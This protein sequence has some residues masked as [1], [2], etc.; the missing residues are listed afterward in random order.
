MDKDSISTK[1]RA[2]LILKE[3]F[4]HK[5]DG[6]YLAYEYAGFYPD[7]KLDNNQDILDILNIDSSDKYDIYFR[8]DDINIW[9]K[10]REYKTN[11]IM[12]NIK[13][14]HEH[15]VSPIRQRINDMFNNE[16]RIRLETC[17]LSPSGLRA[18][19][20]DGNHIFGEARAFMIN[21][22]NGRSSAIYTDLCHWASDKRDDDRDLWE[23]EIPPMNYG[24]MKLC[25]IDDPRQRIYI[26]M[27][28]SE[29]ELKNDKLLSKNKSNF[30][31]TACND[32]RT[33]QDANT[34]T[35][36]IPAYQNDNDVEKDLSNQIDD[37]EEQ[38]SKLE[39]QKILAQREKDF[40]RAEQLEQQIEAVNIDKDFIQDPPYDLS[41]QELKIKK[42]EK[43]Y[44]AFP[45]EENKKKVE[46]QKKELEKYPSINDSGDK[47]FEK[48]KTYQTDILLKIVPEEERMK[49]FFEASTLDDP[50]AVKPTQV[51]DKLG[52]VKKPGYADKEKKVN[53]RK[54]QLTEIGQS[55]AFYDYFQARRMV[56]LKQIIDVNATKEY[57]LDE[58]KM[59]KFVAER[60]SIYDL[61]YNEEF[62]KAYNEEYKKRFPNGNEEGISNTPILV[63]KKFINMSKYG[64]ST[65]TYESKDL[66]VYNLF[67]NNIKNSILKND[68]YKIYLNNNEWNYQENTNNPTGS[69]D[70]YVNKTDGFI[71]VGK[72]QNELKMRSFNNK[73]FDDNGTFCIFIEVNPTNVSNWTDIFLTPT[74]IGDLRIEASSKVNG[75]TREFVM[76]C[77]RGGEQISSTGGVPVQLNQWNRFIFYKSGDEIIL[78]GKNSDGTISIC[79]LKNSRL[80]NVR[81]LNVIKFVKRMSAKFRLTICNTIIPNMDEFFDLEDEKFFP[82]KTI[83]EWNPP[84]KEAYEEL[85]KAE[86]EA[87]FY[88]NRQDLN[89]LYESKNVNDMNKCDLTADIKSLNISEL[90]YLDRENVEYAKYPLLKAL[91]DEN[92]IRKSLKT[93]SESIKTTETISQYINKTFVD[94]TFY[95]WLLLDKSDY[96]D[97]QQVYFD[98]QYEANKSIPDIDKKMSLSRSIANYFNEHKFRIDVIPSKDTLE[99]ANYC[100]TFLLAEIS[101]YTSLDDT[102]QLTK[103]NEIKAKYEAALEK[104]DYTIFDLKEF[105]SD[106]YQFSSTEYDTAKSK[107]LRNIF[108]NLTED[109]NK[110]LL[111][112]VAFRIHQESISLPGKRY[113][114]I[115][116]K[117]VGQYSLLTQLI[118]VHIDE[119]MSNKDYFRQDVTEEDVEFTD[120]MKTNLASISTKIEE[121]ITKFND[122]LDKY[123]DFIYKIIFSY[124]DAVITNKFYKDTVENYNFKDYGLD[125]TN[126]YSQINKI[127]D[128]DENDD[129]DYE[130]RL[131]RDRIIRKRSLKYL[132]QPDIDI[133]LDNAYDEL[134]AAYDFNKI[135]RINELE[136]E[137]IP[138]LLR[139]K[140]LKESLNLT[141]DR[142]ESL[143]RRRDL[144]YERLEYLASIR[145]EDISLLYRKVTFKNTF[146]FENDIM[147]YDKLS[148]NKTQ[149]YVKY[150]RKNIELI[151][152]SNYP[153]LAKEVPVI[154]AEIAYC[155]NKNNEKS[156]KRTEMMEKL[157]EKQKEIKI[158]LQ[159]RN[160]DKEY[161]H[162]ITMVNMYHHYLKSLYKDYGKVETLPSTG[163]VIK[164]PFYMYE[165]FEAEYKRFFS[166]RPDI[167]I[168][169][170]EILDAYR[171]YTN[172]SF[173]LYHKEKA[174]YFIENRK[175]WRNMDYR[176]HNDTM[177]SKVHTYILKVPEYKDISLYKNIF[178]ILNNIAGYIFIETSVS[179]DRH[180][181][182]LLQFRR[183]SSGLIYDIKYFLKYMFGF[184]DQ[185]VNDN[186]VITEITD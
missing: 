64:P 100:M 170:Y 102:T 166:D 35:K 172:I 82:Y 146:D 184:S 46:T 178:Y 167:I 99:Y 139:L 171:K 36:V 41:E 83:P 11:K 74:S 175:L 63:N 179:N 109:M 85:F 98:T 149:K 62:K 52:P 134:K 37:L 13:Y 30:Y 169:N 4:D 10:N 69:G 40:K 138:E 95:T 143:L 145:R 159:K 77:G 51:N 27:P 111:A 115:C 56:L 110:R 50:S 128:D 84:L 42:A 78:K 154:E 15:M 26:T 17:Y 112:Y 108:T 135:P 153:E 71:Y 43:I 20:L 118:K 164:Y 94:E 176:P 80:S 70:I 114:N 28:F 32:L 155:E 158:E 180:K 23:E 142:L 136:Q 21:V 174:R 181:R 173:N 54:K 6:K 129:K 14:I 117:D 144:E 1:E 93:E 66:S 34:S 160:D 89:T 148:L 65:S 76:Y 162:Q 60:L 183:T 120:P 103:L 152:E 45:T 90:D 12:D 157:A 47:A 151:N 122:Y 163:N 53:K 96:I 86:D 38:V 39:D 61:N 113:F 59:N 126:F 9:K 8:H 132:R 156:A 125:Y 124:D 25:N 48:L 19:H 5:V 22:V 116:N 121:F 186:L 7:M 119:A 67:T 92:N 130:V 24:L 57:V 127:L 73:Y 105:K 97:I 141:N 88:K 58:S 137:I 91:I 3:V 168:S 33:I 150:L 75:T 133:Q 49:K 55:Q 147:E 29:E 81:N 104:Q 177:T 2:E 161:L 68:D 16:V 123:N 87:N 131:I 44:E 72:D 107:F 18:Y 182:L 165:E 106:I 185:Y 31:H 101:A 79:T 140:N